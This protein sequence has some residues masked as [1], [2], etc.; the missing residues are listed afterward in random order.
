MHALHQYL[1]LVDFVAGLICTESEGFFL[2]EHS[3]SMIHVYVSFPHHETRQQSS[4][5]L[6]G[7]VVRH[8]EGGDAPLGGRGTA[9]EGQ[10]KVR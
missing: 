3:V 8:D 1:Y 9:E 4:G 10:T 7:A 6:P 5:P 2:L